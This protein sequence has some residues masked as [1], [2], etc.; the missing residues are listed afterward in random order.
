[1]AANTLPDA[2]AGGKRLSDREVSELMG[3]AGHP[4]ARRTV[5][6][7]RARLGFAANAESRGG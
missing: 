5:A 4:M 7:Y 3:R 1:M 6:K 2:G